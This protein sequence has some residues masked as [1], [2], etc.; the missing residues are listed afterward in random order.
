MLLL[1]R[2]ETAA[3]ALKE[4]TQ[5]VPGHPFY[6]IGLAAA[7]AHLGRLDE[8]GAPLKLLTPG[9]IGG[10]LALFRTP[11]DRELLRS[12]LVLAGADV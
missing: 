6:R 4:A 7:F 11:E 5:L 12:G 9:Q 3:T 1:R 8:A 10:V 2:F